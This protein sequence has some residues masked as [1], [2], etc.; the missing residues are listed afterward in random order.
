VDEAPQLR[1]FPQVAAEVAAQLAE[2]AAAIPCSELQHAVSHG[3]FSD[4]LLHLFAV[5]ACTSRRS[6]PEVLFYRSARA[7]LL[8]LFE[9]KS[10][11]FSIIFEAKIHR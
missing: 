4:F 3:T 11:P 5:A 1:G 8:P 10:W 9:G 6:A 7:G 2:Q